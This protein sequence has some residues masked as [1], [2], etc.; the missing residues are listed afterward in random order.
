MSDMP[1]DRFSYPFG[2]IAMK[3]ATPPAS[4]I[5]AMDSSKLSSLITNHS[6]SGI[7]TGLGAACKGIVG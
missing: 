3:A 1:N 5:L 7:S 6:T 4:L 2:V